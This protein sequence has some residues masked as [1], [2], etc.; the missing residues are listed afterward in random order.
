MA[1]ANTPRSAR[2]R[3]RLDPVERDLETVRFTLPLPPSTNN[4]WRVGRGRVYPSP[5][6]VT[7][8]RA[9]DSAAAVQQLDAASFRQCE[10]RIVLPQRCTGDI[11]N[12]VKPVLD[13]MQHYG[14]VTDDAEC[15]RLFVE[16]ADTPD[17][18]AVTIILTG[19]VLVAR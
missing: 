19:K 1:Q 9:A 16:W 4:L 3:R 10:I 13:W 15:C 2:S 7:G 11:D 12:Y 17:D 14:L 8:K 18:T 5:A 6:Y